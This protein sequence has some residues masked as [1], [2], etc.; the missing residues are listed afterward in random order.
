MITEMCWDPDN[1]LE[2]VEFLGQGRWFFWREGD[3]LIISALDFMPATVKTMGRIF[4]QNSLNEVDPHS[5]RTMIVTPGQWIEFDGAT[6]GYG[7]RDKG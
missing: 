7:R 3:S 5:Q 2:A 4:A 1:P 6:F